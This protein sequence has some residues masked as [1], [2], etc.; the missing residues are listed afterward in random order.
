MRRDLKVRDD[1]TGL[2]GLVPVVSGPPRVGDPVKLG[3]LVAVIVSDIGAS[4]TAAKPLV[5]TWPAD[6]NRQPHR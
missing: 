1:E 4:R 3:D 5:P 6:R 2:A